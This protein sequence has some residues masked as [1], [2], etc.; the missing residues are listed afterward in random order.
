M[1]DSSRQTKSHWQEAM[2]I[3]AQVKKVNL[4]REVL[5]GCSSSCSSSGG[6]SSSSA[7]TIFDRQ[8]P[9]LK[10]IAAFVAMGRLLDCQSVSPPRPP[11][12]PRQEKLEEK[13]VANK[14]DQHTLE[15]EYHLSL[16]C[17][18]PE[19][20]PL[21]NHSKILP[22]F[23]RGS[24]I[25]GEED[26]KLMTVP[27][28]YEIRIANIQAKVEFVPNELTRPKKLILKE[29]VE[30]L[31]IQSC[32]PGIRTKTRFKLVLYPDGKAHSMEFSAFFEHWPR[33]IDWDAWESNLRG[34]SIVM[35]TLRQNFISDDDDDLLMIF[36]PTVFS[37]N[38]SRF[39]VTEAFSNTE[40]KTHNGCL[41][42]AVFDLMQQVSYTT[43]NWYHK[44]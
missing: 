22:S 15:M 44:Y 14:Y 16:A 26:D 41:L 37:A 38:S 3:H 7:A 40:L 8:V 18:L 30:C 17:A 10:R 32:F 19:I 42:R 25:R 28:G 24:W 33:P 2:Q 20:G 5:N 23:C 31:A 1:R 39:G 29:Q 11:P 4:L 27:P 35:Q 9:S 34:R 36:D 21:L 13:Q 43:K 12:S 6:L